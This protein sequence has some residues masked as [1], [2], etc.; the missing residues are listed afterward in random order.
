MARKLG[1]PERTCERLS[2]DIDQY[3]M[4]TQ[5]ESINIGGYVAAFMCDQ[6]YSIPESMRIFA[7]VVNS[8]VHACYAEEFEN[9]PLSFKPVAC[10]DMNYTGVCKDS[11]NDEQN[12]VGR[13]V[14]SK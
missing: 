7:T 2:D 11:L 6:G 12:P 1:F 8:G 5:Q 9:Q 4:E 14:P 13:P 10:E 3:L